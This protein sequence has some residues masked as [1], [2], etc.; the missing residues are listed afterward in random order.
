MKNGAALMIELGPSGKR[1]KGDHGDDA[2]AGDDGDDGAM[3]EAFDALVSALGVK[4]KDRDA[5]LE[6]FEAFVHCCK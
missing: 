4:P 2:D 6:A 3:G 5:A 1:G